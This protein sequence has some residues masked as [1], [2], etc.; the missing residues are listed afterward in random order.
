MSKTEFSLLCIGVLLF[1]I[2][3]TVVFGCHDKPSLFIGSLGAFG[4]IATLYVAFKIFVTYNAPGDIQKKRFEL[5]DNALAFFTTKRFLIATSDDHVYYLYLT[6]QRLDYPLQG[7]RQDGLESKPAIISIE[8]FEYLLDFQNQ[9]E[10]HYFPVE[11]K[12]LILS[13]LPQALTS[14]SDKNFK[15]KIRVTFKLDSDEYGYPM[16]TNGAIDIY[17]FINSM[18]TVRTAMIAYLN[19][20]VPRKHQIIDE[21]I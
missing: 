6:K 10:H 16:M 1:S 5:V 11:L 18:N 7:L 4:T 14:L 9:L 13:N 20:K 8:F 2:V 21:K 17:G 19:N 3:T 15:D 12:M